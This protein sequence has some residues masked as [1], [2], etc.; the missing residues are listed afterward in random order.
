MKAKKDHVNV[1]EVDETNDQ[2]KI[3]FDVIGKQSKSNLEACIKNTKT[4]SYCNELQEPVTST[5]S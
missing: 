1:Y 2:L 4:V 3:I 5:E